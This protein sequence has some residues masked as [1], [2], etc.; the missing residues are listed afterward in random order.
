MR[1][2][3]D[4]NVLISG[5]IAKRGIPGEILSCWEQESFEL[6]ASAPILEELDRVIRYPKIQQHYNLPDAVI[7]RFLQSLRRQATIVEPSEKI[8]AIRSDPTDNM[9]LECATAGGAS[10]IVSGD[11]HLIQLQSYRGI[12]ILSPAA[13][14][15][16]LRMED[17]E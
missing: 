15:V 9:Y 11:A 1:V 7:S 14:L 4:V 3:L 13:F 5:F 2:V 6:L 10:Y 17:T 12:D 8:E 16:V